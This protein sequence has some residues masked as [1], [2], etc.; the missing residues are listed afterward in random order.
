MKSSVI[1]IVRCIPF[2]LVMVL[3]ASASSFAQ[4]DKPSPTKDREKDAIEALLNEVRQI[5]LAVGHLND[6]QILVD[7]VRAS[8]EHVDRLSK[9][10]EQIRQQIQE[11]EFILPQ[12]NQELEKAV[13]N[14]DLG[15]AVH[16]DIDRLKTNIERQNAL[17][18]AARDREILLNKDLEQEQVVL[19]DLKVR[20][21][22]VER[23]IEKQLS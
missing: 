6:A 23:E 14:V 11:S 17:Q 22:R 1:R 16:D 4:A 13:K 19:T 3:A 21:G 7:H 10:V 9:E 20:L 8:Q 15:I 18:Q 5:R 2:V 12:L